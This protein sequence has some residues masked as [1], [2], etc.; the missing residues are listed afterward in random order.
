[1]LQCYSAT[2]LQCY[3]ATVLQWLWQKLKFLIPRC[4]LTST[5]PPAPRCDWPSGTSARVSSSPSST[6]SGPTATSSCTTDS[7][8]QTTSRTALLSGKEQEQEQENDTTS[9]RLGV[10]KTDVLSSARLALLEK[11][12]IHSQKFHLRCSL[13]VQFV[14]CSV[15]LVVCAV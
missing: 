3:S 15:C 8:S 4:R 7:C 14:P 2:V 1:M 12:G 10:A 11:L 6:G 5:R 13:N 9:P